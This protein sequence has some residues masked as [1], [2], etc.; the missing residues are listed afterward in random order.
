M[1]VGMEIMYTVPYGSLVAECDGAY[2]GRRNKY[3]WFW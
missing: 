3:V 2:G 1:A